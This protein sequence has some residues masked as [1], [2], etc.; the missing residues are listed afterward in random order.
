MIV[1]WEGPGGG[2]LETLLPV[3]WKVRVNKGY[4]KN[5]KLRCIGSEDNQL[6][7]AIFDLISGVSF[8]WTQ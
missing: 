5:P 3:S 1:R 2:E 8:M 7:V 6:A 4:P